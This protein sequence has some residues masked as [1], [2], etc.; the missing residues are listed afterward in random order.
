[1]AYETLS[2]TE[3]AQIERVWMAVDEGQIERARAELSGLERTRRDHPDVRVVAAA[4]ALEEAD[5]V[6][7]IERLRGAEQSA[8]P[9]FFFFLRARARFESCDFAGAREDAGKSLAIQ[10]DAPELHDLLSR[11]ADHLGRPEAA[12]EHAA[13]AS[14]LEPELFPLP[15]VVSDEDFDAIVERSLAE[16]PTEVRRHLEE[17]PVIVDDLPSREMLTGESPPL[18]PDLLGLFVGRHLMERSFA[19]TPGAPG[20]IHLFRRNLLRM[21]RTREEL[22][23]EIQTTVRHEVGHLLGLDEDDLEDWGL[24]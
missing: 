5:P 20:T 12:A 19:D 1:L 8:D 7:A 10:P 11:I 6:T 23:D 24:A 2:E 16:L 17:W 15:M 9:A 14:D 3:W 4:L 13:E 22:E 18:S 21:C